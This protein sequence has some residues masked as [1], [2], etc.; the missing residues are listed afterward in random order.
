MPYLDP[1]PN[2]PGESSPPPAWLFGDEF[3]VQAK[4]R[5]EALFKVN[6]NGR[7]FVQGENGSILNERVDE[8]RSVLRR[9]SAYM[10]P[11][12]V[13]LSF[14][15]LGDYD[16]VVP[17]DNYD[18]AARDAYFLAN[19]TADFVS[20]GKGYL[21]WSTDPDGVIGYSLEEDSTIFGNL[22][23]LLPFLKV[24]LAATTAN[25]A[26]Y[27]SIS[28]PPVVDTNRLLEIEI[29]R[30]I[31]ASFEWHV[32]YANEAVADVDGSYIDELPCL[33]GESGADG[34]AAGMIDVRLGSDFA[35]T[36]IENYS[37]GALRWASATVQGLPMAF[38]VDPGPCEIWACP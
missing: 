38:V 26:I 21:I 6:R 12:V 29:I 31:C 9:D 37:S 34:C 36:G 14:S 17:N 32:I 33:S 22:N 18:S 19:P 13:A 15:D 3:A 25:T 20:S 4:T 35:L 24:R 30:E 27:W 16:M 11:H 10:R 2:Q 5:L 1:R 23:F 28:P 8:I 7:L